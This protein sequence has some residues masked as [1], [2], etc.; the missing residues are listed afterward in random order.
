M[1][2]VDTTI[3]FCECHDP[4]HLVKIDHDKEYGSI[5]FYIS[6]HPHPNFFVRLWRGLKFAFSGKNYI[7]GDMVLSVAETRRMSEALKK[8]A[9]YEEA[10]DQ[11]GSSEQV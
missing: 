10:K 8:A 3:Y 7:Y 9:D 5:D 1:D 4:S 2:D 11:S 6:S